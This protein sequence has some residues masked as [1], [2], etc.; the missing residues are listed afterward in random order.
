MSRHNPVRVQTHEFEY[1]RQEAGLRVHV[2]LNMRVTL[3]ERNVWSEAGQLLYRRMEEP[4]APELSDRQHLIIQ[5]MPYTVSPL[6]A[7]LAFADICRT[8]AS[9]VC[10]S[11]LYLPFL[12][13]T[14]LLQ[15]FSG[16]LID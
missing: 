1:L 10:W 15:K 2:E 3:E 7:H 16:A 14:S 11:A 9:A 12:G 6:S 5:R 13:Q 4:S 8:S